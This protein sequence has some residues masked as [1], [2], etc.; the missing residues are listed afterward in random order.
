M[1]GSRQ[2]CYGKNICR[3]RLRYVDTYIL[4]LL[5]VLFLVVE[6]IKEL[7]NSQKIINKMVTVSLHLFIIPIKIWIKFFNQKI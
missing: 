1:F 3:C 2:E 7:Q 4:R 5:I 6:L